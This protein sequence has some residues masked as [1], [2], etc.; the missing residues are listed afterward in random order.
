MHTNIK[1]AFMF[2]FFF[3]LAPLTLTGQKPGKPEQPRCRVGN[4]SVASEKLRDMTASIGLHVITILFE[5][6]LSSCDPPPSFIL[7]F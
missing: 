1:Q 5:C 7:I 4:L 3:T 2:F 6:I